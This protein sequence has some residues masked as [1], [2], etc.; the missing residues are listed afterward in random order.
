MPQ[1][2]EPPCPIPGCEGVNSKNN[3]RIHYLRHA[4]MHLPEIGYFFICPFCGEASKRLTDNLLRHL[5]KC[6][7]RRKELP[8]EEY[9]DAVKKNIFLR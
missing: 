4:G 1:R 5:E 8:K 2:D 3:G 9:T 6:E 7:G